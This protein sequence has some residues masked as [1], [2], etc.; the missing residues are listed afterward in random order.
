MPAEFYLSLLE[1]VINFSEISSQKN[2]DEGFRRAYGQMGP[3]LGV[4]TNLG[5]EQRKGEKGT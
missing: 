1:D 3:F 4:Q 5:L 2:S